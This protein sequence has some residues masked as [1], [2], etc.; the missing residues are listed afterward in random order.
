MN[1]I[2]IDTNYRND[3]DLKFGGGGA[4]V[5]IVNV[6]GADLNVIDI[7]NVVDDGTAGDNGV[8]DNHNT[9]MNFK[10]RLLRGGPVRGLVE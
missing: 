3:D 6:A 7:D 4:G 9:N 1:N 8:R 5:D 2:N 10:S